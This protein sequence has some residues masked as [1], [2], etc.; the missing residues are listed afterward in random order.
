MAAIKINGKEVTRGENVQMVPPEDIFIVEDKAHPLYEPPS[1]SNMGIEELAHAL[2]SHG[3]ITPINIWK[4]GDKYFAATGRRRCKAAIRANEILKERGNKPEFKLKCLVVIGDVEKAKVVSILENIRKVESPLTV[5][6]K[7]CELLNQRG[8]P[9]PESIKAVARDFQCSE[10]TI[11][12]Y[13]KICSLSKP[14]QAAIDEGKIATHAAVKLAD[15]P[16]DEQKKALDETLASGEKPTVSNTVKTAKAHGGK[17]TA[18]PRMRSYKECMEQ[19][20][21]VRGSIVKDEDHD[22][23]E[24]GFIQGLKFAMGDDEQRYFSTDKEEAK[25]RK[26]EKE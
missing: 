5:A 17:A 18:A 4:D 10:Q 9:G 8:G 3:Q 14:V 20:R 19:L 23:H 12:N 13:I 6:R 11:R 22:D 15:L 7:A 24:A 2:I 26:E 1:E 25:A 21:T 16:A